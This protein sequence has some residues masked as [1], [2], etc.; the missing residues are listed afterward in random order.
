[1]D[2]HT[3]NGPVRLAQL[4]RTAR[5]L[6]LDLTDDTCLAGTLPE[7]HDQLDIITARPQPAEPAAMLLRPDCYVAW[8]TASPHPDATEREALRAALQRWLRTT[9]PTRT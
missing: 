9:E 3:P 2:L 8:A 5:P 1:M 6:L 7:W 4:T